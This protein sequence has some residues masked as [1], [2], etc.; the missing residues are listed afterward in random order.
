[1]VLDVVVGRDF[2][3]IHVVAFLKGI[4]AFPQLYHAGDIRVAYID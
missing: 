3:L 4:Y 2:A 1:M